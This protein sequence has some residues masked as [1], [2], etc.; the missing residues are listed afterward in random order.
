MVFGQA[1]VYAYKGYA[2]VLLGLFGG[3]LI[4]KHDGKHQRYDECI[5]GEDVPHNRPTSLDALFSNEVARVP[6]AEVVHNLTREPS[7]NRGTNT[8]SHQHKESLR[9]S[10]HASV[11]L[12]LNEERTRNV[13]EVERYAID[14]HRCKECHKANETLGRADAEEAEAEYP[15]Q[16]RHNHHTLNTE[17][18]EADRDKEYAQRLRDLRERGEQRRI[19]CKPAWVFARSERVDIRASEAIGNLQ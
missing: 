14:N 3:V 15:R 1:Q 12:L 7:T 10:L 6:R 13:E 8:V 9:R 4:L 19:L 11:G 18:L 17:A 2:G 16:H 5:A